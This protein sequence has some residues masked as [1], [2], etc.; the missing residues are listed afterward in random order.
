MSPVV[1]GASGGSGK[2]SLLAITQYAPALIATYAFSGITNLTAVDTA[3]VTLP[4]VVPPSGNVI[5]ACNVFTWQQNLL[6]MYGIGLL[7][8]AGGAQVGDTW[9]FGISGF[10]AANNFQPWL[11]VHPTFY[12][13]GLTPGPLQV[14]LAAATTSGNFT[15]YAQAVTGGPNTAKASPLIMAAY[16]A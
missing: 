7:N 1:S 13:T 8:H 16:Q 15:L 14:D 9:Q 3:N 11:T 6:G 2:G 4:F 12:L 5:V 10:V